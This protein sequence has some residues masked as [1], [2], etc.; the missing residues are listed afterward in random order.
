MITEFGKFI[1]KL[2]IEKDEILKNMSDKL[3]VSPAYLSAVENGK[4]KIPSNWEVKL[5]QIY[6]LSVEEA[7]NLKI[8]IVKTN[9]MIEFPINNIS[10]EKEEFLIAF[11]RKFNNMSDEEFTELRK[12]IEH[13][14]NKE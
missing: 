10:S 3:G 9:D 11:A 5:I 2:R 12:I 8:A 13:T 7:E 6:N 4:R 14:N 1:R